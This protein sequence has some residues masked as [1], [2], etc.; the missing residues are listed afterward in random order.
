MAG[1][2]VW[3]FAKAS[4]SLIELEGKEAVEYDLVSA[5]GGKVVAVDVT[6]LAMQVCPRKQAQGAGKVCD[7]LAH[8]G[9]APAVPSRN[10]VRRQ[11]LLPAQDQGHPLQGAAPHLRGGGRGPAGEGRHRD[12]EVGGGLR[13]NKQTHQHE[14][15]HQPSPAG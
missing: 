1:T 10:V 8:S 5:C 3:E 7:H 13:Q 9:R 2:R 14:L 12:A 11:R 4:G 15:V 6:C